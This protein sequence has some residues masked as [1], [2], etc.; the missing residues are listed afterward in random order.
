MLID[1]QDPRCIICLGEAGMTRAHVIPAAVGGQLSV[2]FE[3]LGCNHRLGRTV[4]SRLKHDPCVRVGI[5]AIA[6]RVPRLASRMRAQ[7]PFVAIDEGVRV[8]AHWA[9]DRFRVRDTPQPDRSIV[10]GPGRARADIETSLRRAGASQAEITRALSSHD[11]APLCELVPLARGLKIRKGQVAG[12]QPDRARGGRVEDECLLAIAYRFLAIGIGE[13]VY[14]PALDGIRAALSEHSDD[15]DW[16]VD[17]LI[18]RRPHEPWH[19]LAIRELTPHVVVEVRLFG[20]IAWDVTFVTVGLA[21]PPRA[22]V[23]EIELDG[24]MDERLQ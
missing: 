3:C 2:P 12:F 18:A 11:E 16:R 5:E 14:S 9:R 17:W 7:A 8:D 23:Y 15:A 20:Q 13:T 1:W 19:G 24:A 22:T 6:D 21:F 4:E 10:K